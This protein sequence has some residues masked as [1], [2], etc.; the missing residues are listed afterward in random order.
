MRTK[1]KVIYLE[2][3]G[4]KSYKFTHN[5]HKTYSIIEVVNDQQLRISVKL[6]KH[7]NIEIQ[8]EEKS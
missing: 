5:S 3:R 2:S 4:S 6:V 8:R 1:N 7:S